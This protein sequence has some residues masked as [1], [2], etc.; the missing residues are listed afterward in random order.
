MSRTQI[1]TTGG[2]INVASSLTPQRL[3]AVDLYVKSVVI[4][5][6]TS[7]TDFVFIGDSLSQVIALEPRR[8]AVIWGDNMD[9]GTAAKIN[10]K[11]VF[12]RCL[13]NGEGV[14]FSYLRGL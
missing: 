7:N 11:D 6:L 5:G 4:Q 8:N 3:S 9:N 13:V 14:A 10:L 2:V 1:F 12:V